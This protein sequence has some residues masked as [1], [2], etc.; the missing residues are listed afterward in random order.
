M[1]SDSSLFSKKIQ[2]DTDDPLDVLVDA[3]ESIIS[4]DEML[5]QKSN[6][7]VFISNEKDGYALRQ[8]K[9]SHLR[10]NLSKITDFVKDGKSIHPPTSI[11]R[12]ILD[13]GSWRDIRSLR[14]VSS[15]PPIDHHGNIAE[16]KGYHEKTQVYF[17][18][19]VQCN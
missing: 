13:K 7:L 19:E 3:A 4:K 14:A 5:F 15:F 11:A 16:K 6:E 18:G 1:N 2:L 10:Y 17:T 9:T 12:C 8:L